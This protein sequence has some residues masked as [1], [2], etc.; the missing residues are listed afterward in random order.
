VTRVGLA[1]NTNSSDIRGTVTDPSGASV[2]NAGVTV[3]NQGTNFE[4]TMQTDENGDYRIAGLG[5]GSYQVS[6]SA[7]GFKTFVRSAIVLDS[8]QIKR[9]DSNLELGE[10]TSTV[11][12]KGDIGHINTLKKYFRSI[13][14][15]CFAIHD[16]KYLGSGT[17]SPSESSF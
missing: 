6:V 11:T 14:N 7:P 8:S 16:L 1:Q 10:A 12:V 5:A 17:R 9:V 13:D 4:R 2:A 3:K 15:I